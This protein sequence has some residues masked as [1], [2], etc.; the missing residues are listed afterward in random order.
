MM[1]KKLGKVCTVFICGL[2]V[3][4]MGSITAYASDKTVRL[5]VPGV[6]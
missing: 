5:T 2:L 1:A 4:F 3:F 6:T